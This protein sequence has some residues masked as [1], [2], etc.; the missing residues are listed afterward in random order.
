MF[1]PKAKRIPKELLAHGHKRIDN[2]FWLNNRKN[3]EVIKYLKAENDYTSYMMKDTELL[4][5]K[6]FSEIIS[7]FKQKDVT[8][9]F[10]YNGYFYYTRYEEGK[11]YPVHCRKKGNLDAPEE[12]MLNVNEMAEGYKYYRVAGLNI[13]PDNKILVFGEDTAGRRLYNIRFKDLTTGEF[14]EDKI[15]N[16]SGRAEWAND[17]KTVFYSVRDE[18]LRPYKIY[19]HKLAT[20]ISGD[21]EIFYEDDPTFGVYVYRTK[22]NKFIVIGSYSTVSTEFHILDADNPSGKFKVFQSREKHLEYSIT[23]LDNKFFIN[24]NYKA[25]NFRV[26]ETPD[27]KTSKENWKEVIPHK[28]DV[29]IERMEIFNNFLVLQERKNGLSQIKIVNINNKTD[30]CIAFEEAAYN[31]YLG[32]NREMDSDELRFVYSSL[33]TP[34]ST[35]D[36][37]MKTKEKELL[38]REEVL[39]DFKP[40]NYRTERL[41]AKAKDGTSVPISLVYKRGLN[42]D[43]ENPLLLYGYGSYGITTDPDF[44]SVRLSLLDRGFIFAIAHIRGGQEMGRHWYEEGKLYHKKNTFSDFISCAEYLIEYKYTNP[45]KLF[46]MGGSAGGLLMGAVANLRPDLFRGIIA[47]VPFVDVVTTMLD[48]TI[49]LTTVEYDEWGNPNLK[50]Y[51]DYILSY[52]PYDNVE[53]KDYPPMLVTAGLHDSQ[54]QYW[55]PAKW[56][57]KLREMKTDK[58]LLLL[59]TNMSAGH[60]GASGRFER[61]KETVLEYA[62][63]L[64]LIDLNQIASV[65]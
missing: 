37:N 34:A 59:Y 33:T 16:T 38:K 44:N 45:N 11:E 53:S 30:H 47:S 8:V 12:I 14:L 9:P 5:Q 25:K 1:P 24:T 28:K 20:D 46:A 55:E 65:D 19:R 48:E 43:V 32:T 63:I 13:S 15:Q 23:N 4:Q 18:S 60:S 29:L 56:V 42:R 54:V 17:N 35:Y 51:Y 3:P 61:Y 64:D 7:R 31:V 40:E 26:M 62:F 10:R 21:D 41:Y 2:Y 6:L 49:P 36:Y 57:A 58:N 52:S 22:S 50:E 39:G 27:N